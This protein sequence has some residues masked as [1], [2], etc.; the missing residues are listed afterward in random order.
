M[1]SKTEN[2]NANEPAENLVP[3]RRVEILDHEPITTRRP[4]ALVGEHAYAAIWRYI[5]RHIAKQ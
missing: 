4:L 5:K 3:A 1:V 2:G